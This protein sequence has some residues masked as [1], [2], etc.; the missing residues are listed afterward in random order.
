MLKSYRLIVYSTCVFLLL[1]CNA[2][3]PISAQEVIDK[4]NTAGLAI[5]DVRAGE[6]TSDSPLPNSYKERLEF[7][8]QEVAPKG[9]QVF[10]CDTKRNCD[11]IYAYFDALIALAGPYLYQSPNGMVVTQLNSGLTPETAAKFEEVIKS[12]P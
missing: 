12:L 4:L 5:T 1:A 9:G 6:R 7:S 11:A 10:V 8:I 2:S 3:T